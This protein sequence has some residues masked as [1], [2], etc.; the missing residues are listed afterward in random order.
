MKKL[1]ASDP[2]TKTGCAA[3]GGGRVR[4]IIGGR[5]ESRK[6]RKRRVTSGSERSGVV[7]HG[8]VFS[9]AAN[10]RRRR[11]KMGIIQQ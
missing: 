4:G 8:C 1:E 2:G 6:E 7:T 11:R 3:P 10:W 5:E 9:H